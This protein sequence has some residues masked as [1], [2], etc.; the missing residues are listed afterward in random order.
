MPT[1]AAH[2]N[3]LTTDQEQVLNVRGATALDI[4]VAGNSAYLR[5]SYRIGGM[6]TGLGVPELH[7]PKLLI[8]TDEAIDEV[9]ILSGTPGLPANQRARVTVIAT[10]D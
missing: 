10:R 7:I 8:M 3:I 6:P 4:T 1:V 5:F 9:S 2:N